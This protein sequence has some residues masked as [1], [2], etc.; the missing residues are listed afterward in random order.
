MADMEQMR[1]ARASEGGYPLGR[2]HAAE[3]WTPAFAGVTEE[4]MAPGGQWR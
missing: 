4:N 2:R 3:A 1:G